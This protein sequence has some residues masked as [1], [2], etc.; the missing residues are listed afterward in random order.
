MENI[1]IQ[2]LVPCMEMFSVE[3]FLFFHPL[4]QAATECKRKESNSC[5]GDVFYINY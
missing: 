1:E 3:L 2:V 4:V 5:G